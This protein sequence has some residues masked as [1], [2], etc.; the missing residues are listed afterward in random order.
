M[1]TRFIR[2]KEAAQRSGYHIVT[3]RRK[4]RDPED[5]FPP[6]VQL[7]PSSFGIVESEFEEWASRRIAERDGGATA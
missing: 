3:V 6:L 1:A 2:P 7:G 4:A 5:D